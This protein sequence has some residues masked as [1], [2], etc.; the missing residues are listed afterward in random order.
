MIPAYI[1]I[2]STAAYSIDD[3]FSPVTRENI[4]SIELKFIRD[5]AY[6][7]EIPD[8]AYTHEIPEYDHVIP[9]VIIRSVI[10]VL[11]GKTATRRCPYRN[12]M[13]WIQR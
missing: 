8:R 4:I 12:R 2:F 9:K 3:N 10:V 1:V 7:H 13:N 5:R 6:T 11:E